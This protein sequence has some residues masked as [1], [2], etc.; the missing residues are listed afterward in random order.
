[1]ADTG[2]Q[3][4]NARFRCTDEA[5]AKTNEQPGIGTMRLELA[6]AMDH[7]LMRLVQVIDWDAIP[8][9]YRPMDCPERW[10]RWVENPF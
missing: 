7:E 3:G 2:K 6:I 4:K 8:A 9:E 5:K 1:M 10:R